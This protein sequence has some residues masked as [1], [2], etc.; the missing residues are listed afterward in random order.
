MNEHIHFLQAFLKNP[1]H[2]GAITPSSPELAL[3]MIEDIRPNDE[4]VVL[5]LGV[6]TGSFTKL[7]N[8]IVP[9]DNSYL[10]VEISRDFIKSLKKEYP[11]LKFVCGNAVKL[12]KLHE[13]SG[14]GKV[15]YIISGIP[16]VTLPNDVGDEIL[17]EISKFMER[18]CMFRTFQYAHGYYMPSAVKLRKFMRARYG[19]ARKSQLIMKNVPPAYS[20]TWQT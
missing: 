1:L 13:K 4:D 8:H 9:D 17:Y 12:Q 20:L 19:R 2:V 3:Q 16:F 14:L 10:G 5:E 6:G 15:S 7:I 11:A 18:G